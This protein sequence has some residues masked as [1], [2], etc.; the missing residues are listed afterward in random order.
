VYAFLTLDRKIRNFNDL[1]C[2]HNV[3]RAYEK[4]L[5]EFP[6]GDGRYLVVRRPS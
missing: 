2:R 1:I 5:E 3:M 4:A 6:H